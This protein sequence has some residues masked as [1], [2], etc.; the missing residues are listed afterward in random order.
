M[1]MI[2]HLHHALTFELL[3]HTWIIQICTV[4]TMLCYCVTIQS[5]YCLGKRTITDKIKRTGRHVKGSSAAHYYHSCH[6]I[7]CCYLEHIDLVT[8]YITTESFIGSIA[9]LSLVLFISFCKSSTFYM[10]QSCKGV[11]VCSYKLTVNI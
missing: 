4:C 3:T 6:G 2:T 7:Y 5:L 1:F 10:S 8:L 9:F 11:H